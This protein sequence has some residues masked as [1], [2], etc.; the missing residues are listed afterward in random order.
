M[1]VIINREKSHLSIFKAPIKT[2]IQTNT[3]K[4]RKYENFIFNQL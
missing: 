1:G 2:K 4:I 3:E